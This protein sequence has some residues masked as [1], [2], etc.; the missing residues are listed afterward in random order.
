[1]VSVT[2]SLLLSHASSMCL[3]KSE[4]W[5]VLNNSFVCTKDPIKDLID[6]LE[7]MMN[8]DSSVYRYTTS[9]PMLFYQYPQDWPG[10]TRASLVKYVQESHW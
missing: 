7:D 1:M 4:F 2:L 3:H 9:A 5:F 6:T 10:L 8:P